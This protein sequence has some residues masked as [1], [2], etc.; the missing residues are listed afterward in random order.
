MDY[1]ISI[2][3]DDQGVMIPS[4]KLNEDDFFYKDKLKVLDS[5]NLIRYL[6][7]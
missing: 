7:I 4:I 6:E 2:E 1:G 3:N 5:A